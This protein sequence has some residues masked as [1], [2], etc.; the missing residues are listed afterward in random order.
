MD[1]TIGE[2]KTVGNTLEI[3]FK[4]TEF[5]NYEQYYQAITEGSIGLGIVPDEFLD[6]KMC[7]NAVSV[8]G[9]NLRFV[10]EEIK[11][12]ELCEIAVEDTPFA[13]KYVPKEITFSQKVYD[14]CFKSSDGM[15]LYIPDNF[16]T[17]EMVER[18]LSD[19]DYVKDPSNPGE[20]IT[21]HD[22][23]MHEKASSFMSK[24]NKRNFLDKCA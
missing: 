22:F 19:Y 15:F 3:D 7:L 23:D 4:T 9:S 21:I 10:P 6:A 2:S 18:V 11:N 16:V 1:K 5:E 24:I 14:S 8:D 12:F 20:I 17:L 13:L